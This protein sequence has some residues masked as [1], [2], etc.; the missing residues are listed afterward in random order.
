MRA[1]VLL[2]ILMTPA[3]TGCGEGAFGASRGESYSPPAEV[4][5]FVEG[6]IIDIGPD[7]PIV[8]EETSVQGRQVAAL[9]EKLVLKVE[10]DDQL[11]YVMQ[12]FDG[13]FHRM[14]N[15]RMGLAEGDR[16][17]FPSHITG[18]SWRNGRRDHFS[19]NRIGTVSGDDITIL[20]GSQAPR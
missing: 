4:T 8:L 16:V 1:L 2:L 11:V 13:S 15:L 19:P 10:G 12:V 9:R 17:R 14:E 5:T 18:G 7:N 3:L 6:K 20:S